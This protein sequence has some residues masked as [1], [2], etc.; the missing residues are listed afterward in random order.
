MEEARQAALEGRFQQARFVLN[1]ELP[2]LAHLVNHLPPRFAEVGTARTRDTGA[3]GE[4]F[5]DPDFVD[6]LSLPQLAT[7]WAHEVLHLA[8]GF[9]RRRGERDLRRFNVAHDHAINLALDAFMARRPGLLAWTEAPFEPYLDRAYEGLAAEEIYERLAI[10]EAPAAGRG[11]PDATDCEEGPGGNGEEDRDNRWRMALAE[12]VEL[13]ARRGAGELPDSVAR[14]VGGILR[15][16]VPWTERLLGDLEGHLRGGPLSYARPSRRGLGAGVLL[17]GRARRR[18]ALALIFDTSAS[19]Q[20]R[21]L[22]AFL[23]LARRLAEGSEASLRVLEVDAL[24]QRDREVE[25]LD[26]EFG[27]GFTLR[28]GGGTCFDDLPGALAHHPE[29]EP[30]DLALLLTDGEPQAWPPHES[31]SCPLV[32][33]TTRTSPPPPYGYVRMELD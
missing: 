6:Q 30:P 33:V 27:P 25:D 11:Y 20:T 9:F 26:S 4:L 10:E 14:L 12:A 19:I 18:P 24:L 29:W 13:E 8:F 32:V 23:G 31:W 1:R 28:G 21:E 2:F 17:P 3:W 5:F 16:R 22:Q 15:P 7:V